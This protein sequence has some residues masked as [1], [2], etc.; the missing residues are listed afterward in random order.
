MEVIDGRTWL[1]H[2]SPGDGWVLLASAPV[3]RIGILNDSAPEIY[4]VTHVVDQVGAY[5]C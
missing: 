5:W 2:I 3:G 1:E 4:P